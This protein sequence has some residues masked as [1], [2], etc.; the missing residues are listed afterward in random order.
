L[1]TGVVTGLNSF[2]T[3]SVTGLRVEQTQLPVLPPEEP[4][5]EPPEL[6]PDEPLPLPED[7]ELEPPSPPRPPRIGVLEALDTA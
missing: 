3:G 7:V 2:V 4:E 6:P 1:V 5:D